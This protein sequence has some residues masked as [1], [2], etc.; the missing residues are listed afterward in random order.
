MDV[1]PSS[2]AG[3]FEVYVNQKLVHSKLTIPG[4][5][6]VQTDQELDAIIDAVQPLVG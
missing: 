1:H 2:G 6:K 5:G 4:H 3:A